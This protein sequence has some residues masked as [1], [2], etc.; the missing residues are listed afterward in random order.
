MYK[1]SR[2]SQWR[3]K[4]HHHVPFVSLPTAFPISRI[5]DPGTCLLRVTD[6]HQCEWMIMWRCQQQPWKWTLNSPQMLSW[7]K[8]DVEL[9]IHHWQRRTT[10]LRDEASRYQ[11]LSEFTTSER[12]PSALPVLRKHEKSYVLALERQH[13][14][15]VVHRI[16]DS[17]RF[18]FPY[19][20]SNIA[21]IENLNIRSIQPPHC[22]EKGCPEGKWLF[23]RDWLGSLQFC[24]EKCWRMG[25]DSSGLALLL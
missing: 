10:Q 2:K 12:V 11:R 13:P 21:R 5:L 1:W 17:K 15:I 23:K 18:F 3:S 20:D 8:Q 14:Q 6:T 7:T 22:T 9:C 24:W 16:R 25:V 19:S 4:E